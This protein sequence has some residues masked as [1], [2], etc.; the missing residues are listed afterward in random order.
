MPFK[1]VSK[2]SLKKEFVVLGF[3][4][5]ANISE[6]CRRYGIT[7]PTGYK[8][9]RRFDRHGDDGLAERSRR[10]LRSPRKVDEATEELIISMRDERPSWGARKIKR[11]LENI[12]C[13]G[14]PSPSTITEI[15]RRNGC[16]NEKGGAKKWKRFESDEPM[17][18][19][20]MDFKGHF[21]MGSG[22][23]HPLTVLDDHSRYLL[24]LGACGNEKAAT[25]KT[26]LK[27]VFR[28]YGLPR[29]IITDN[30][31]PWGMAGQ[32]ASLTD[33]GLWLIRLGIEL[34]RAGAYHPQTM[35]KIERLHRTLKAEVIQA[36]QFR[37]L[38][39]CQRSFDE[40]REEYNFERPHEAIGM[41]TPSER[42]RISDI[43]FPETM[44]EI[45]YSPGD[46]IRK[47]SA[48]GTICFKAKRYRVGKGLKGS[49]V[50]VREVGDGVYDVVYVRQKLLRVKL[51]DAPSGASRAGTKQM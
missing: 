29:A 9:L 48:G 17:V 31:P 25:V 38:S 36:R 51:L 22:R 32:P 47:V 44:P 50:A 19:L 26:R 1:E 41:I 7:R 39:D 18:L 2:M 24:D 34:K 20:Q 6:L 35:G 37:S 5:G 12:G 30:G 23:C 27:E 8:W 46:K 16:L 43:V 28:R 3:Q 40:W 11:Y 4:P 49:P 45:E 14:L 33:L 10:P 15:L 21:K 42:F 13:S